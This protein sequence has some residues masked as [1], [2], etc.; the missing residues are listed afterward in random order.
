[1]DELTLMPALELARMVRQKK[2]GVE[3]LLELHLGRYERFHSKLNAV[4]F[5]QIDQARTRARAADTALAGGETWGPL[6]GLPITIKD[7]FDWVGSPSTWGIPAMRDNYPKE[8]AV[9][10]QRLEDAGAIIYGKTNVPLK[11]GDWQSFNDIYGTTNNP[12]DLSCTPGGSSGGAAVA[13]ATGMASLEIGS[14]IGASIRNPAHYSG[15]FGHKPTMG[16]VPLDGHQ[17]P[18]DHTFFDILVAGPLARTAGDLSAA[19]NVLA[20][21]AGPDSTG[22][23]LKLPPPRKSRLADFKAGVMLQSPV[24]AQEDELTRQLEVTV[25]GLARAGVQVDMNARPEIDMERCQHVYMTLLRAALGT[26]DSVEEFEAKRKQAGKR[27]PDDRT[28]QAY[29]D[30]GASIYHREWWQLHNEREAMRIRWAE[31]FH[32]YDLLLCPAAASAAFPHDHTGE[33]ADRTIPIN[34]RQE[35]VTDQLFWAGLSGLVYLPS[36]VAPAG[37]TRSGLPCGLQ[38]VAGY[39]EDTTALEFALL[40]EQELGGFQIA[41]GYE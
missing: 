19:L 38:I 22:W 5:C 41:R 13:L 11:L 15:V 1:M 7:S 30:R 2:V 34:G 35:P 12:W 27:H 24:C 25:D 18:G 17:L 29:M 40:M 8:N 6:H 4:I 16:I 37:M 14:D 39:L 33:R 32:D 23:R 28:C 31:Y 9:V 3:E 36:T 20:G 10:V 21:A 26:R